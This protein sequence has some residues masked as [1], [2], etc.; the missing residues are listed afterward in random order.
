MEEYDATEMIHDEYSEPIY[1]DYKA[2]QLVKADYTPY[3]LP[4]TLISSHGGQSKANYEP[5]T[6]AEEPRSSKKVSK[7]TGIQLKDDLSVETFVQFK[8]QWDAYHLTKDLTAEQKRSQLM[9]YAIAGRAKTLINIQFGDK[10]KTATAESII[11]ALKE[12][13]AGHLGVRQKQAV[14]KRVKQNLR[15]TSLINLFLDLELAFSVRF[16]ATAEE[17]ILAAFEAFSSE[18]LAKNVAAREREYRNSWNDFQRVANEEWGAMGAEDTLP[19]E[20]AKLQ[21]R[22]NMLESKS[23][24]QFQ[25]LNA[26]KERSRNREAI[27]CFRCGRN[28]HYKQ[29]CQVQIDKQP[30]KYCKKHGENYSHT[31]AQCKSLPN[32]FADTRDDGRQQNPRQNVQFIDRVDLINPAVSKINNH[33]ISKYNRFISSAQPKIAESNCSGDSENSKFGQSLLSKSVE[34]KIEIDNSYISGASNE[35][36]LLES[37][38]K[39]DTPKIN[40]ISK[41]NEVIEKTNK[42]MEKVNS[43]TNSSAL[44]CHQAMSDMYAKEVSR[45]KKGENAISRNKVKRAKWRGK[46]NQINSIIDVEIL[47]VHGVLNRNTKEQILVDTGAKSNVVRKELVQKLGLMKQIMPTDVELTAANNSSLRVLGKVKIAVEWCK[48]DTFKR[49]PEA[50]NYTLYQSQVDSVNSIFDYPSSS[51]SDTTGDIDKFIIEFIVVEQL[52]VPIIVGMKGICQMKMKMDFESEM[53]MVN[54][55]G[56]PFINTRRISP[57]QATKETKILPQTISTI[58]IE[59]E[60][61]EAIYSIEDA[62]QLPISVIES[63]FTAKDGENKFKIWVRNMNKESIIIPKNAIIAIA[64]NPNPIIEKKGLKIQISFDGDTKTVAAIEDCA[65]EKPNQ[66]KDYQERV[67]LIENG[68]RIQRDD[69]VMGRNISNKERE[70]LFQLIKKEEVTFKEKLTEEIRSNQLP[71]YTMKLKGD[72]IPHIAAMG[73]MSPD[74]ESLLE[75]EIADLL[76]RGLIELSDGTWRA[77]VVLV[78]K[79]DGKWRRCI[80]YRVLNDMTVADSYPMVR[81]DETL[82]QLG[83]AKYFSKLDMVEGYY[84]IPLHESSKPFTGF[85]TRS[86]FYQ[87]RYLPMGFKNAGAAFQRQM[88]TVLGNMR[89]KFCIPYIDDIII[90]SNTFGEHLEH[91]R[92]VFEQ[93]RKFGLLV[94]MSKCEFCMDRMDFLGHEVSAEGLRPNANKVRAINAMPTPTDA[95]QLIRF[96]AM[97]GFYRRYIKNFA[98][99]THTVRSLCKQNN[100]W[101][102][103]EKHQEEI[104]DI[105][106][107][108]TTEP[109][110]AYPDWDR[111]FILTTDASLQGLGAILSQQHKD[112]ER[113]IAYASRALADGEKRWGITELEALAVVWGTEQFKVYLED[114]PFDLITDHKALLAF[115]KITNSNPR[116]ERWSIKLS[117]FE[118]DVIYRKGEDNVNADC[119]SRDPINLVNTNDD[120][121]MKQ[122]NDDIYAQNVQKLIRKKGTIEIIERD[123]EY[124][125]I[126][127]FKIDENQWFIEKSGKV[128]NRI[129]NNH[130]DKYIDRIIVPKSLRRSVLQECHETGHFDYDR[131]YDKLKERF[132]WSGM[133]RD[134]QEF[135]KSCEICQ[136]RN[137]TTAFNRGLMISPKVERKFEL[138]GIDLY[139]GIP[140]G[141]VTNYEKILVITDYLTKWVTAIPIKD[142]KARTVAEAIYDHWIVKY[143]APERVISDEGGEFNAEEICKELYEVFKIKKFTTTSYHPQAN[144]QCERF[145]RTMSGMLAKYIDDEQSTWEKYVSTCVLEY[146]CSKHSTTRE[147][148]YFMVF[149]QEPRLPLDL[150][151]SQEEKEMIVENDPRIKERIAKAIVRIKESQKQSKERYDQNRTDEKFKVGEFVLWR[152]QP[153]TNKELGEHKKLMSPWR[154]PVCI[155]RDLGENKYVIVDDESASKIINV[156]NLK[157][158]RERPK[159][160]QSDIPAI[161][162][163]AKPVEGG[164]NI[165]RE[166]NEIERPVLAEIIIQETA[167]TN[168]DPN[169]VRRSNR[170]KEMFKPRKGDLIDLRFADENDGKLYWSCGK[171][172]E[173]DEEDS[174][175]FYL[176]FMDGKDE[177]WYDFRDE[178]LEMR[179]CIP[180]NSHHRSAAKKITNIQVISQPNESTNKQIRMKAKRQ[181]QK[182]NKSK[183]SKRER[184]TIG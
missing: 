71:K 107:A 150:A 70:K 34:K 77:R 69:L 63:G 91:L 45:A 135:V 57:L 55:K 148:P 10:L 61:R 175:R 5:D 143:G 169:Q 166:P 79:K 111:K 4:R 46:T 123:G 87:W 59:G 54:N 83:K 128:Y 15:E 160:M 47:K 17:K 43:K 30:A 179:R 72:A 89:F 3:K 108:L 98:S 119:L 151:L 66:N 101:S 121:W 100:Q 42:I 96:L 23:S 120:E 32:R 114:R 84:Q 126:N 68:K 65:I 21:S 78:K 20:V 115:K 99:R 125:L 149:E 93:F 162:E 2:N 73:R 88:D 80:D 180:S 19:V 58:E 105:K 86:G 18:K 116:L 52:S 132:Y 170:Q 130:K 153:T 95:K 137:H 152:Q 163:A 14:I 109:V 106:R 27:K 110:M 181:R 33:S 12:K 62:N 48:E 133:S 28:G 60:L 131:T 94:K 90:Y 145:N 11:E 177:D 157:K 64:N 85:A 41:P 159:W 81:I 7:Y 113:V 146:N 171:I 173:I 136:R 139:S 44:Y 35:K 127:T 49:N 178:E 117:R 25:E 154:G 142:G 36:I 103:T 56:Y 144:G 97:A 29:D 182:E 138:I 40:S 134:T 141:S 13:I 167:E 102:W 67:N 129:Y 183:N 74:K 122:Q 158:Y 156:R 172:E 124:D 165:P 168:D 37:S 8:G 161:G 118:Y 53:I 16:T 24:Q 50:F 38:T 31:T 39:A 147:S 6:R 112:G 51:I 140:K 9:D 82:D 76:E 174:K 184:E 164:A 92:Q 176:K 26:I 22:I 155:A 104:N 75:K 1:Y